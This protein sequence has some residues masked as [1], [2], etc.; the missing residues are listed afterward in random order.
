MTQVL[1]C[2]P[3]ASPYTN[4]LEATNQLVQMAKIII[5]RLLI[6]TRYM[7]SCSVFRSPIKLDNDPKCLEDRAVPAEQPQAFASHC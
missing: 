6:K 3:A 7:A 1:A 5:G 2:L 4:E